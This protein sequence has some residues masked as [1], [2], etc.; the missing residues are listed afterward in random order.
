[1]KIEIECKKEDLEKVNEALQPFVKDFEVGYK[2]S[3]EKAI[4]S[5]KAQ[6]IGFSKKIEMFMPPEIVCHTMIKNGKV[7]I[8]NSLPD[9][10]IAKVTGQ[11][12]KLVA[13]VTG[14]LEH[15]GF[16]NFKVKMV[17]HE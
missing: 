11:Y 17:K 10:K 8:I 5:K 6:L 2:E 3:L 7:Y 12:R 13:G 1:M 9:N 16:N 14:Y 15:T 4:K